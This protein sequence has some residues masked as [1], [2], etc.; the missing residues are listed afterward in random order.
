MALPFGYTVAT[1]RETNCSYCGRDSA[2]EADHVVARQFFPDE[3]AY[4]SNLPKVPSCGGCNRAKQRVEDT[5]GVYLQFGHGS[6]ASRQVL[7][8]RV[9]CT[10][11]KN[12]RLAR[13]LRHSLGRIIVPKESGVLSP[14]LAFRLDDAVLAHIHD[15]FAF[16]V[17]GLYRHETGESLP[18]DHSIHLLKATTKKQHEILLNVIRQDSRHV[19]RDLAQGELQYVFTLSR[20]DPI[21]SWLLA[22][23][24]VDVFAVTLG[25]ECPE[26][27][28]RS[29]EAHAW[30]RP[31][32]P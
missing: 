26:S 28:R 10:L 16:V 18:T 17:K 3:G 8:K 1:S 29:T 14:G 23:K 12:Q 32:I 20:V 19:R 7:E 6:D 2:E 31:A 21:S 30:K 24:S 9:P 25:P 27:V 15:W 11:K 5:V 22:F 13:S 4:R